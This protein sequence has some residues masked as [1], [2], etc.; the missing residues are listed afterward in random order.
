MKWQYQIWG[1]TSHV[2]RISSFYGKIYWTHFCRTEGKNKHWP[3]LPATFLVCNLSIIWMQGMRSFTL[4]ALREGGKRRSDDATK[5][6][7]ISKDS[8][9]RKETMYGFSPYSL[10][11]TPWHIVLPRKDE[12]LSCF[13]SFF[14]SN[15]SPQV[16]Q[17]I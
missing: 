15:Y 8:E 10:V 7:E 5:T 9:N 3:L 6:N 14:L 13:S 1:N 17:G 4:Q 2:I 12:L 16:H 11:R